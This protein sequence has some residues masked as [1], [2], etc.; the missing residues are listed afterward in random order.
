MG[1]SA[2]QLDKVFKMTCVGLNQIEPS[3]GNFSNN[4]NTNVK[5]DNVDV[6]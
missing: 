1:G 3:R 5:P 4:F 2:L 6:D